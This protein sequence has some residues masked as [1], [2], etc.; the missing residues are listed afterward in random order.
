MPPS[1]GMTLRLLGAL[2]LALLLAVTLGLAVGAVPL[3]P[4]AVWQAIFG[5]GDPS[6]VAIVQGLRL[7]RV[8]LGVIVG[9]GLATSGTAINN[10]NTIV[11]NHCTIVAQQIPT[12]GGAAV[13]LSG[14]A[15]MTTPE[16]SKSS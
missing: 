2:L 16:Q 14:T 15:T 9:A 1:D 8:T 3:A 11:L 12:D 4:A 7:P 6:A 13:S 10:Q 5:V